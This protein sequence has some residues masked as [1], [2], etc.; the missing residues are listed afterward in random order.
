MQKAPAIGWGLGRARSNRS[1]YSSKAWN[2]G[3]ILS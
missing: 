2:V 3:T 1:V